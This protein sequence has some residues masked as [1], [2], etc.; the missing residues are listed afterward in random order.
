M[1]IAA[2][3]DI[4]G[5][6]AALEA[7]LTDIEVHGVDYVV[8]LGDLASLGPFPRRV[9]KRI[10]SLGCPVVQGNT[11]AWYK[12]PLPDGWEPANQKQALAYDCYVWLEGQLTSAMHDFL[13]E[14]PLTQRIGPV[15]CVHGSPRDFNEGMLPDT[16]RAKL[17][18][19]LSDVPR[20]IEVILCGHTHVPMHRKLSM[21]GSA[22]SRKLSVVNC[23][24][25]GMPTDGNPC[26]CYALLQR[27]NE[28]WQVQW[29]RPTYDVEPAVYAAQR[30]GMPHIDTI[31]DAWRSGL[32]LLA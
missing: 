6:L 1:R 26:P 31:T 9:I 24:S 13:L 12:E 27:G 16:S 15:L 4:H 19:M 32:G 7:V 10:Q 3:S 22:S 25:V 18:A 21:T 5:N 20:D 17:A 23:G 11:D 8:C 30:T 29:R 14:L 2:I 28:G